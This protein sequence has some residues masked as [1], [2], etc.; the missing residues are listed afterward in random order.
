MKRTTIILALLMLP[1]LTMA[2]SDAVEAFKAKYKDDRDATVVTISGS[3]FG[4][5]SQIASY[6]DDEDEE[7]QAMARVADGI[8]QFQVL[9]V[10]Y[11]RSGLK[12]TE[13]DD[14]KAAIEGEKY[15]ELMQSRERE[16]SMTFYAQQSNAEVKN[17]LVLIDEY[18]EFTILDIDGT[19]SMKDLS[20]LVKHH[21]DFH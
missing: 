10:R 8:K 13:V 5:I 2:Q 12:P 21:R 20:T 15:D 19:L 7:L 9:S 1:M 14:L 11:S 6:G 3:M 17:M 16:K 18:D 4:L